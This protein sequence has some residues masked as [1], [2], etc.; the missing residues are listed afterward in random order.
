MMGIWHWLEQQPGNP[1]LKRIR[2]SILAGSFW[3]MM[4][5]RE[6]EL[7]HAVPQPLCKPSLDEDVKAIKMGIGETAVTFDGNASMNT[8][9]TQKVELLADWKDWDD[10]STDSPGTGRP[11][12]LC[13]PGPGPVRIQTGQ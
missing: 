8:W 2:K 13:R 11:E 3:M 5:Y 4:P 10:T 1:D 7:V 6:L 12:C 9:S